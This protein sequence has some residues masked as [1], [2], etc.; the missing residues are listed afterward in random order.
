MPPI[1]PIGAK[2][3]VVA[4]YDEPDGRYTATLSVQSVSDVVDI[5]GR[6]LVTAPDGS[7]VPGSNLQGNCYLQVLKWFTRR[8]WSIHP[9]MAKLAISQ[10]LRLVDPKETAKYMKQ[11]RGARVYDLYVMGA[12]TK[13]IQEFEKAAG[14]PSG[15][16]QIQAAARTYA[17]S[18]GK[19]DPVPPSG[20]K[21]GQSRGNKG[22]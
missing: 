6:F 8:K 18:I 1:K 4:Y 15:R 11:S 12:T 16:T 10:M 21:K 5:Y 20:W 14:Q 7:I 3:E 19:P 17:K 2:T 9:E 13:D 22:Q